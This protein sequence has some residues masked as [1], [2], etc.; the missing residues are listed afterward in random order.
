MSVST[1]CVTKT[2]CSSCVQPAVIARRMLSAECACTMLRRPSDWASP[3]MAVSCSTVMVGAPPSPRPRDAKSLMACAPLRCRARTMAR[4]ES[5]REASVMALSAVMRRGPDKSPRASASRSGTSAA[6]PMLCIVV[7]PAASVRRRLS[8]TSGCARCAESPSPKPRNLP[9]RSYDAGCAWTS[10]RPGS[11]V[12]SGK[13]S[14]AFAARPGVMR[15]M[16]PFSMKTVALGVTPPRPSSTQRA[17]IARGIVPWASCCAKAGALA[18]MHVA[19]A[20]ARS[21]RA[22]NGR[23]APR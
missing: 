11:S 19:S 22:R 17:K 13:A 2:P 21:R 6:A 16:R 15:V 10:M 9:A 23:R 20:H 7:K 1:S 8:A 4:S 5:V 12:P 3:Q 14:V 18:T